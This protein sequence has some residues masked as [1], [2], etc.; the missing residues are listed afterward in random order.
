MGVN[1]FLPLNLGGKSSGKYLPASMKYYTQ[2]P[3]LIK[4]KAKTVI[5]YQQRPSDKHY[6]GIFMNI[7]EIL[8]KLIIKTTLNILTLLFSYIVNKI[9]HL[10]YQ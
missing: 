8:I 4:N 5:S 7:K 3:L 10:N 2:Q 6:S 9:S 1:Y